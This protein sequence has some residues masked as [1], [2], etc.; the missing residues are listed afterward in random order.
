M[1]GILKFLYVMLRRGFAFGGAKRM[2]RSQHASSIWGFMTLGVETI[3]LDFG[4]SEVNLDLVPGH[5][6]SW[7]DEKGQVIFLKK[8]VTLEKFSFLW[9]LSLSSL[10]SQVWSHLLSLHAWELTQEYASRT[11]SSLGPNYRQLSHLAL[12][13]FYFLSNTWWLPF[14]WSQVLGYF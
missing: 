2:D 9:S 7:M 1:F 6:M 5:G 10:L 13:S 8:R 4:V 3:S 14:F 12:L 11:N